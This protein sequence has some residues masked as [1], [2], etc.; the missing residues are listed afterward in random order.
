MARDS[1]FQPVS[2]TKPI[3]A[4]AVLMLVEDGRFGLDA[5]IAELAAP[6]V[7]RTPRSPV[8]DDVPAA[9]PITVRDLL[10]FR[11]GYGFPSDFSLPQLQELFTVQTGGRE[12]RLRPEPGGWLARLARIPLPHQPGESWLYD[13]CAD[14][15]GILIARASGVPAAQRDRFARYYRS[16]ENQPR[17][18]RGQPGLPRRPGPG[19]R[20][21]DRG[22]S[23][24][25]TAGPAAPEPALA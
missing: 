19:L 1:V 7:V 17:A 5:P 9:R 24:A 16:A 10:T 22:R 21:R 20:R 14:L 15:Q 6:M 25:A 8:D 3:T 18:A 13:T 4:A 2:S 12:A 23:R 11:A